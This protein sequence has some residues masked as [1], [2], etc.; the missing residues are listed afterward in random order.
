MTRGRPFILAL[1]AGSIPAL[2]AVSIFDTEPFLLYNA[3]PS[4]PIGFYNVEDRNPLTV[5]DL[6]A[7]RV[8]E[9]YRSLFAERGYLPK[10]VPVM[11]RIVAA[12]GDHVCLRSGAVYLNSDYLAEPLETDSLGRPMPIWTGCRVLDQ[13]EFFL[14]MTDVPS[15]LDSR[16]FGPV[17]RSDIIGRARPI[18]V[19][20]PGLSNRSPMCR[21]R[22]CRKTSLR[23]PEGKIKGPTPWVALSQV[24][25][26]FG[27]CHA[28]FGLSPHFPVSR[29]SN[30]ENHGA[31][32]RS[33]RVFKGLEAWLGEGG[34][35]HDW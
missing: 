4:A 19:S 28:P 27:A 2:L 31:N 17:T 6:V 33:F 20:T 9:G 22:I 29:C 1:I 3:S 8:P 13:D 32:L 24:C 11:K 12:E 7:A 15:S 23:R 14:A 18:A 5:G 26:S 16:Y 30:C 34:R 25:T 35:N 10:N 21:Q